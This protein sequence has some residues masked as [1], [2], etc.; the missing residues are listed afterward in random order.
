LG[1]TCVE[2]MGEQ[3]TTNGVGQRVVTID[4]R[5]RVEV[6]AAHGAEMV[7]K[8]ALKLVD[9]QVR[10]EVKGT[11]HRIVLL[12]MEPERQFGQ[13]AKN[14]QMEEEESAAS[15]SICIMARLMLAEISV[16]FQEAGSWT[17]S[18]GNT[19]C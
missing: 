6:H 8:V 16:V 9:R 7:E 10:R 1:A 15:Y 14:R 19:D 5:G 4:E 2:G 11:V 17:A 13:A 18:C 12:T 3:I